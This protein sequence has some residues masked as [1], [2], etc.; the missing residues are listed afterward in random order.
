VYGRRLVDFA[1]WHDLLCRYE[2]DSWAV[3][4]SECQVEVKKW[5]WFARVVERNFFCD[6]VELSALSARTGAPLQKPRHP[7][8]KEKKKTSQAKVAG[9]TAAIMTQCR[10]LWCRS[11]SNEQVLCVGAQQG[12]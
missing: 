11:E 2:Q 9:E 5:R 12:G 7:S 4:I 10:Y 6:N 1:H 8:N 3:G